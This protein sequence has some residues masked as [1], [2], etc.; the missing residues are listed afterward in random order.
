MRAIQALLL[1]T[2]NIFFAIFVI[3][4]FYFSIVLSRMREPTIDIK[5]LSPGQQPE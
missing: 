1:V 5:L 3:L 4:S 2:G